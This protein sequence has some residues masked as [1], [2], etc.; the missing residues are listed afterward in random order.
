MQILAQIMVHCKIYERILILIYA[1]RKCTT[2]PQG[3]QML[4]YYSNTEKSAV[5]DE[6][7]LYDLII[8]FAF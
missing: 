3:K 4:N 2:S 7:A 6:T 5:L 8:F 1:E